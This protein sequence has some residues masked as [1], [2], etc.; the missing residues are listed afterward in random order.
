M[1]N[2]EKRT[3]FKL[4][5]ATFAIMS[6][7]DIFFLLPGWLARNGRMDL[8]Q[9]GWVMGIFYVST[10]LRPFVGW[11]VNLTGFR[12]LYRGAAGLCIA[13]TLG[14]GLF[15]GVFPALLVSRVAMGAGFS[16]FAVALTAY[17][18]LA[19][20]RKGSGAAF[21]LS[22]AAG[23]LPLLVVTPLA[24]WM[25]NR[26]MGFSFLFLL[27]LATLLV[28][29]LSADSLPGLAG[30]E[31]PE[32]GRDQGFAASTIRLLSNR[33]SRAVVVSI[34][35]FCV[36]DALLLN[37]ASLAAEKKVV[38]SGFFAALA[39]TSF[40]TRVLGRSVLN[41]LSGARWVSSS[42]GIVALVVL[43]VATPAVDSS[44][45]LAACG[46]LYG[47]ASGYGYPLH[48][49]LI[50]ETAPPELRGHL[51]S[52]F[53]FFMGL[54]YFVMPPVVGKLAPAAG[55]PFAL[56]AV[57]FLVFVSAFFMHYRVWKPISEKRE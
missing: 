49:A 21:A 9:I 2:A 43:L 25:V 39:V 10:F 50:G 41:R 44:A 14:F 26:G 1:T 27:P 52:L 51:S 42:N 34:T 16:L 18:T 24:E 23:I 35:L 38:V 3:I 12:N 30:V 15:Q 6:F 5:L 19:F 53:W 13:G 28:A 11:F 20:P 47:F 55:L 7:A 29:L 8:R 46:V 4:S 45:R 22:S 33:G 31:R 32:P 56:Q 57:A 48:L 36:V 54:C 37:L 17:Q 40:L